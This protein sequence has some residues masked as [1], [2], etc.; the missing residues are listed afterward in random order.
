MRF[1][2]EPSIENMSAKYESLEINT[3]L[4]PLRDGFSSSF[5][6]PLLSNTS[7][8]IVPPEVGIGLFYTYPENESI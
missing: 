4:K 2:E 1:P 8:L 6:S 7:L 3:W 5:S